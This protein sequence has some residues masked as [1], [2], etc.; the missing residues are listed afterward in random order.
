MT[1]MMTNS[2][3]D[4]ES[5]AEWRDAQLEKWPLAKSNYLDLGRVE[6]RN[7]Q[8]G[9][10]EGGL[11]FN[12][13]RIISTGAKTDKASIAKR[14][15]FLCPSHR[16]TEQESI[17]VLDGWDLLVNPFPIFPMHFTISSSRHI[18]QSAPPVEMVELE[19]RCRE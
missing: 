14:P 3:F 15:C 7:I 1:T 19:R 11:Q 9:E 2:R 13:A 4:I 10:M 5:L 18:P 12:P 16:P 17:E 6:R 8:I